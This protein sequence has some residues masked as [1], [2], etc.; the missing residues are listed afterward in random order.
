MMI[1]KLFY[2]AVLVFVL[3]ACVQIPKEAYFNRGEPES[4]L[5]VSSEVVNLKIESGA[6][7]QE[8]THWINQDQPTRAELNCPDGE[9]LCARVQKVLHQFG[10]PVKYTSVS[11]NNVVLVYERVLAR[12]CENRYIDNFVNPYNLNHPSFGC[13]LSVNSVQMVTDKRQFTSPALMDNP[14]AFRAA[15]GNA[16]YHQPNTFAPVA[17]DGNFQ[18]EATS[19]S[20]SSGGGSGGGGGGGGGSR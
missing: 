18:P 20:I 17:V 14:D 19:Q 2:N 5:D 11:D 6:S 8:I 3:V 1:K 12:D 7:V 4:L 9:A 15:Q 13:S 16:F 10:V